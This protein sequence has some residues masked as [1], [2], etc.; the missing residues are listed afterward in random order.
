MKIAL[1]GCTKKKR[2]ICSKAIDL[3]DKSDFFCK[4]LAYAKKVLN[5]DSVWILSA[6]HHLLSAD[7]MVAPYNVTLVGAKKSER[8]QWATDTFKQIKNTFD[9]KSDELFLLCGTKYYEFLEKPLH[10]CG[11]NYSIPMKDVGGIGKQ[12]QWLKDRL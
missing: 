4:E 3:Y 8:E 1:I 12:L 7:T 10:E 5:V 9:P 2:D 11:Y 6:K